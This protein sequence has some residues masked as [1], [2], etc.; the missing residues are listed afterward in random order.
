VIVAYGASAAQAAKAA[1]TTM[2]IVF[3]T[4]TDPVALG[5]VAGLNRPGAN[6]TG[7]K[8]PLFHGAHPQRTGDA[9]GYRAK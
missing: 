7:R 6:L 5:L 8:A 9:L 4:G 2:P 1:T 3:V